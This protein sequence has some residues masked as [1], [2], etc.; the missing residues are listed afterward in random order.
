MQVVQYDPVPCKGCG[1]ILNP[2]ALVDYATGVW[3]CCL[4]HARNNFPAGYQGISQEVPILS[5]FSS[6][7][8]T[9]C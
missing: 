5:A 8:H 6:V 7:S 1:A 3:T 9:F 2:L 4:C